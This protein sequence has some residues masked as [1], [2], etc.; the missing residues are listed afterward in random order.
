M[1]CAISPRMLFIPWYKRVWE[2]DIPIWANMV[3]E[4]YWIADTPVICVE[5]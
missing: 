1:N 2:A 5:A 3:G 4:K